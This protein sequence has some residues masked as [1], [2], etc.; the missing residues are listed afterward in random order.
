MR[1]GGQGIDIG[2]GF[3]KNL[4]RCMRYRGLGEADTKTETQLTVGRA[5]IDNTRIEISTKGKIKQIRFGFRLIHLDE[6][7][8]DAT[9]P[10]PKREKGE[11]AKDEEADFSRSVVAL[12]F[13]KPVLISK[14]LAIVTTILLRT[15]VRSCIWSEICEMKSQERQLYSK[16]F[17]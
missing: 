17:L 3:S 16:V 4:S 2:I 5:N 1:S 12:N 10:I 15:K 13:A 7:S 6:R 14:Y 11:H 9:P 8:H